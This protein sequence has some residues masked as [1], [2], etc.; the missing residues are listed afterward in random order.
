MIELGVVLGTLVVLAAVVGIRWSEKRNAVP[1]R[2]VKAP[3]P[4]APDKP[5]ETEHERLIRTLSTIDQR[6]ADRMYDLKWFLF[7]LPFIWG[8]VY[9]II[10]IIIL[11]T[12]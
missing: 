8:I 4:K 3:A 10:L 6:A 2:V 1:A 11:E 5:P 7:W 12:R 9:G